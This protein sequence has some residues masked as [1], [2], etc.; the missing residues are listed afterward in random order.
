MNITSRRPGRSRGGWPW[1]WSWEKGALVRKGQWAGQGVVVDCVRLILTAGAVS[2][3]AV[4][5]WRGELSLEGD[6]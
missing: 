2:S 4:L 5:S 3:G 1:T 6:V